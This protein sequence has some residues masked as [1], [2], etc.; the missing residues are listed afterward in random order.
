MERQH[1]FLYCA[2]AL[3]AIGFMATETWAQADSTSNAQVYQ[4][5]LEK[6]LQDNQISAEEQDLLDVLKQSLNLTEE[7]VTQIREDSKRNMIPVL[8]QSGRW[9]FVLQNMLIGASLYAWGIPYVLDVE[10]IKWTVGGEMLSLGITYY[11]TYQLTKT[12]EISNARAQMFRT[13][14][15]FGMRYGG[16]ISSIVK[17]DHPKFLVSAEMLA[18]PLG[19]YL[20]D[21]LYLKWRPSTGHAWAI[22][23]WCELGG[24]TAQDLFATLFKEPEPPDFTKYINDL[25]EWDRLDHKYTN[26]LKKWENKREIAYLLGVP[27]GLAVER[28]FYSQRNYTSG[29]ALMLTWGRI[30]GFVYASLL[31]DLFFGTIDI[32]NPKTMFMRAAGGV[33]G[34]VLADRYV[35]Q[36]D[37]SIGQSTLLFAGGISGGLFAA[38]TGVLLEIKSD[39]INDLLAIGGSLAGF[40]YANKLLKI[41]KVGSSDNRPE[42]IK[43][44]F[45][46]MA[47][48]H[49][50]RFNPGGQVSV[51]F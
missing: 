33:S 11:T 15:F 28:R 8:D 45:I 13:G 5:T 26:D 19:M 4:R 31:T 24:G 39:E 2:V 46:P 7:Q 41:S 1:L 47:T 37:L 10:D 32:S 25:V 48:Y 6:A 44:S 9:Q 36:R 12:M 21:R 30:T 35:R 40:G 50:N 20:T 29:D 42:R 18:I 49:N 51:S 27:L 3:I 38:G 22:S 14:A 23:Q 17:P 43:V 34:I 16:S